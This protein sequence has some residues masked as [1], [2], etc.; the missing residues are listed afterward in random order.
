[1]VVKCWMCDG[2]WVAYVSGSSEPSY[3]VVPGTLKD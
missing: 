3:W 1:M 2:F